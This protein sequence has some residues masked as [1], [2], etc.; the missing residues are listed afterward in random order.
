MFYSARSLLFLVTGIALWLSPA[1]SGA[2]GSFHD[3]LEGLN[4]QIEASPSDPELR[5]GR[6]ALYRSHGLWQRAL[7]DVERAFGAL[8]LSA[9]VADEL[10]LVEAL[11]LANVDE[12]GLRRGVAHGA[13]SYHT[14]GM[15]RGCAAMG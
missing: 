14:T 12:L 1:P 4:R 10:R 15:G 2:H 5:I 11:A 3:R 7:A 13:R 6:S 9:Q 8:E